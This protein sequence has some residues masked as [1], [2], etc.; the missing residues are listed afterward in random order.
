MITENKISNR[1]FKW[2][3]VQEPHEEDLNR[4]NTEFDLPYLLVQDTLKPEHLPKYENADEGHFLML[5]SFDAGSDLDS[6]TVQDITRKIALFITDERLVTIHRVELDILNKVAERCSKSE[7]PKT[8]QGLVH[9]VVLAII[10]SYEEP[11]EKLQDL[12]DDFEED[13]LERNS[14]KLNTTRMYIFR[15]R[16]FVMKRM[17]KQ[18]EEALYQFRE[19]WDDHPSMLQD[20]KENCNQLYFRL[21]EISDNFEHLFQLYISLNDQRANEVMKVLTVFSTILLPLNFIA[22]WYGMNFDYLPGLHNKY[23]PIVLTAAMGAISLAAIL[24]FKSKG[25][26][27]SNRLRYETPK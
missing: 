16:L 25:W 13:I 27:K 5:R 12:Y 22:S 2:V 3:D 15:R 20:L 4:L 9:M 21:D 26:F 10:R 17:L 11:L 14:G 19:F 7:H 1:S 6:I 18:T 24:Y 8:I 23:A